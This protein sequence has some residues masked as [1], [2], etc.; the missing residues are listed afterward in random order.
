MPAPRSARRVRPP[1]P[2]PPEA[3][4]PLRL[5]RFLAAAG[6]GS[7]RQ[8]ED[9]I[10]AGRVSIDGQTVSE[11]G[12]RV[13]PESQSVAFDG[14]R[15]RLERKRYYV[16][17][18]PVGYLCTHHDPGGRRNVTE[19]FPAGKPRLFAVG[20]LDEASEGLLIVTNDG[21]LGNKLAHPRYRIDRTYLVQ[22]VGHPTR[23][24]LEELERGMYFAEGKFRAQSARPVKKQ[25]K[26][27]FLE[28][29]LREGQ[30][31]EIRRLLARIGHKVMK[32]QRVGFG[33]LRLGRLK[34][35]EIRELRPAEIEALR[36]LVQKTSAP[37]PRQT[38]PPS[39][40]S[41]PP[42]RQNRQARN[43]RRTK[44]TP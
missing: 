27:T 43:T 29:R 33:P 38:A 20:R 35:G 11:L 3:A 18:K 12:T 30:N 13:D 8:C 16:L 22:V 7:R 6:L 14:E 21:E 32:L 28:I 34:P 40:R 37:Q 24:V 9:Y 36:A 5:Q 31:R 19:L 44:K 15:L 42:P 2:A 1:H 26:S 25:G 41:P 4:G 39:R 23:T 10:L 17:N